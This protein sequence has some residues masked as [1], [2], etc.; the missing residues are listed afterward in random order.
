M[1]WV[2][3]WFRCAIP[4]CSAAHQGI[5]AQPTRTAPS[6]IARKVDLLVSDGAQNCYRAVVLLE[7]LKT[8]CFLCETLRPAPKN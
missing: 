6:E 7:S 3:G 5:E 4:F 8:V 1:W 2:P